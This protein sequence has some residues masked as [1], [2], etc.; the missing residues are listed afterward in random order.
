[1]GTT[2]FINI[3]KMSGFA[4]DCLL[5]VFVES[6]EENKTA[7]SFSGCYIMGFA[8]IFSSVMACSSSYALEYHANLSSKKTFL[9]TSENIKALQ[10]G[11]QRLLTLTSSNGGKR[12]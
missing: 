2:T 7:F 6:E 12:T 8:E 3:S 4:D 5:K 9:Y 11:V 10:L 1:M